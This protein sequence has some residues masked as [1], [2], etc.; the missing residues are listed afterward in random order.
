MPTVRGDGDIYKELARLLRSYFE[1]EAILL[2][3][4]EE[5]RMSSEYHSLIT[6]VSY[7]LEEITLTGGNLVDSSDIRKLFKGQ[8]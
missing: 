4:P 2:R 3:M 7:R 8:K 1:Y 6:S 5:E